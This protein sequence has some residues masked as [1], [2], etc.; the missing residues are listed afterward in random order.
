[1]HA[2][3]EVDATAMAGASTPAQVVVI[4]DF[5]IRTK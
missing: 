5:L 4:L 3:K 2:L 1:V